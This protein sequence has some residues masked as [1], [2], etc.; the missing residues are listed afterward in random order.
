MLGGKEGGRLVK[1]PT[2]VSFPAP[3]QVPID[4]ATALLPVLEFDAGILI[5]QT[6][7]KKDQSK[8]FLFSFAVE[9]CVRGTVR[10][11]SRLRNRKTSLETVIFPQKS[12]QG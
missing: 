6:H 7:E 12:G 1:K 10:Q 3:I 9:D 2:V 8:D 11:A 4:D 5:V